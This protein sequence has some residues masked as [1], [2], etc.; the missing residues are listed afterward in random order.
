MLIG[1][2]KEIKTDEY[3]VAT[4][5]VT[6]RELSAKGHRVMVERTAGVGAGISDQEYTAAGA[7]IVAGSAEIFQRAEL[8]VKVKEPLASER[9]LLRHGQIIFTYLHLAA[10]IEQT[11]DLMASGVAA[12]AYETVTDHAGKLPLLAPM[13]AIAGRMAAQVGPICSSAPREDAASC[14]AISKVPHPPS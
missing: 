10:D 11:R 6:V 2:P 1:I 5:P 7:E 4:T 8:I 14:S 3:R 9:K 12:I 13:S